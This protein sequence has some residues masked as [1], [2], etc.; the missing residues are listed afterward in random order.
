MEHLPQKARCKWAVFT[1]LKHKKEKLGLRI[2]LMGK[3]CNSAFA[4]GGLSAKPSKHNMWWEGRDR[5]NEGRIKERWV[6]HE[7]RTT[8]KEF[9]TVGSWSWLELKIGQGLNS[10]A[11][12][13]QYLHRSQHNHSSFLRGS[14]TES[15]LYHLVP[16]TG[17]T[18]N[19]H[20]FLLD[21]HPIVVKKQ[22]V[23]HLFLCRTAPSRQSKLQ[24]QV[25]KPL[26][27]QDLGE[28]GGYRQYQ[29]AEA[30]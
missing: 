21:G 17:S 4:Y 14:I 26:S 20:S 25:L 23:M 28:G 19:V 2:F 12:C 9:A 30:P 22:G 10:E 13:Q 11:R 6:V 1:P 8:N 3:C 29:Q 27:L 15:P 18:R 16:E 5:Q 7:G 24:L